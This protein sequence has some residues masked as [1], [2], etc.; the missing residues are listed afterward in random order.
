MRFGV[1]LAAF[2][3]LCLPRVAWGSCAAPGPICDAF[4]R[5]ALVFVGEVERIDPP[6]GPMRSGVS[7]R[8]R[9]RTLQ[10]FKGDLG[11]HGELVLKASSEEF[12][13]VLGQR[14]LVYANRA[15]DV[16]S[17]ACTRTKQVSALDGEPLVLQSLVENRPGGVIEGVALTPDLLRSGRAT[18]IRVVLRSGSGDVSEL[19]TDGLGGFQTTWLMPGAYVLSVEDTTQNVQGWRQVVVAPQSRCMS[20]GSIVR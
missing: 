15:G 3:V 13:Y 14:V 4:T 7:T 19:R 8:V 10:R 5:A 20:V 16:W 1:T 17:T 11:Q 18:K 2:I 12:E 6:S 9:F